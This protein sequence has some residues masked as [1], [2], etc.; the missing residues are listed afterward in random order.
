MS[1]S[2]LTCVDCLGCLL[3]SELLPCVFFK[4]F[5]S[6]A[7]VLQGTILSVNSMKEP[8]PDSDLLMSVDLA[9]EQVLVM[10]RL[11]L[12]RWREIISTWHVPGKCF[13][14]SV[15]G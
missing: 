7:K 9:K 6:V 5:L 4:S 2:S 3:A 1:A 11:I 12:G 13:R 10:K 14:Q 8:C 15:K